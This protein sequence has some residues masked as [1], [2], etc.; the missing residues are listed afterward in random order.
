MRVQSRVVVEIIALAIIAII[1]A[2]LLYTQRLGPLALAPSAVTTSQSFSS[3]GATAYCADEQPYICDDVSDCERWERPCWKRQTQLEPGPQWREQPRWE[4]RQDPPL[5]REP[6]APADRWFWT[7]VALGVAL[8]GLFLW[9]LLNQPWVLAAA[10]AA[11]GGGA[12]PAPADAG[13]TAAPRPRSRWTWPRLWPSWPARPT[14]HDPP[15][16][17]WALPLVVV[18]LLVALFLIQIFTLLR[19]G[20]G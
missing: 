6:R 2:R 13:G 9:I 11:G 20:T 12:S 16:S 17:D 14:V 19:A 15:T 7:L 8:L 3:H 18:A 10:P 5:Q 4:P 1:F